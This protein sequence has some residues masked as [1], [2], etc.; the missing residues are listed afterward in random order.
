MGLYQIKNFCMAKE[1]IIKMKRELTVWE[2]VFDKDTL[3]KGFIS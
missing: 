3:D 1:T 2:N